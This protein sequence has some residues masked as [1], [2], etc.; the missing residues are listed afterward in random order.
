MITKRNFILGGCYF[1][2]EYI[3]NICSMFQA[4]P[5]LPEF[6]HGKIISTG[7]TYGKFAQFRCKDEYELVGKC[8][9]KYIKFLHLSK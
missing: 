9:Q 1:Y 2:E 3:T 7:I 4:C 6:P 8:M 5:V